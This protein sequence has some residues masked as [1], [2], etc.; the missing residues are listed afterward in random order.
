MSYSEEALSFAKIPVDHQVRLEDR[1]SF[2]YLEYCLIRQSRTGVVAI[3][4]G[5]D[6]AV[7]CDTLQVPVGGISVLALGP[8]TS[9]ST[10]AI[11]SCTRS[12]LTVLF[13]GGGGVPA[14]SHATPLTSSA[15]WAIAQARLVS[16]E[17]AQRKA[18]KFLYGRQLGI[19]TPEDLSINAMRGLEGRMMR[20]T[21]KQFAKRS[22]ISFK[23]DSGATDPVNSG[24]NIA[25]GILYGCAASACA[26]LGINP[27]LG[28]IHRGNQRSLLFDL[29]D[30][31]KRTIAIPAA[32]D[33][34]NAEDP[35]TAVRVA[36]RKGIHSK[37]V[38]KDMLSVLMQVLAPLLP[39]RDDDRLVGD[40]DEDEAQGHIQYGK[41]N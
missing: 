39:A 21:Y 29:A 12:G 4:Q 36:V 3:S 14:Y 32:F 11:T 31:Y 2:L 33:A 40:A 25:N 13:A 38:L 23:R 15:R 9:I 6:S 19:E 18:A 34:V 24:L 28:I 10:A 41:V 22:R 26:A 1:I 5:D 17:S 7:R 35:A 37:S 30:L 20:D 8:G 27:A 16:D